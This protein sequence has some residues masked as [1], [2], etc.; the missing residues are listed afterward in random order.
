MKLTH[1]QIDIF[2]AVMMT[3]QVTRAAERLH[4]SQPTVSRELARLE[5]VLGLQLFERVQGRLRPTVRALAWMQEVERSY[6]GLERITASAQALQQF[7]EG[8]LE[9]ACLPALAHTLMPPVIA[10]FSQQYPKVRIN[11]I[12]LESPWL[13]TSLSE[14]RYD[15]G[16]TE[17]GQTPA[18]TRSQLLVSADEV[19]V[20]P[21]G[22]ELLRSDRLTPQNFDQQSFISFP[23]S[24]PYR[25][26]IDAVFEAHGVQRQLRLEAGH[27]VAVCALV[28][29]GLGVAIVNPLTASALQNDRLVI[30]A[31]TF[32]VPYQVNVVTPIHKSEHPLKEY[33]VRCLFES[34]KHKIM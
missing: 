23:A 19:A 1:R 25:Q 12:T 30:K 8:C 16:L 22:H 17:H 24:D 18:D 34:V 28:E 27:A 20:L 31:L 33:L 6:V 10:K 7:D 9:V 26:S 2:R 5:K 29:Q 32:S 14:Q 4:T 13:E 11:L 21:V 3:G 15:L